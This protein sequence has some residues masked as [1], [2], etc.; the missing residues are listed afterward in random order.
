MIIKYII[1]FT[2]TIQN[3]SHCFCR[4]SSNSTIHGISNEEFKKLLTAITVDK[5][6]TSKY[7]RALISAEDNRPSAK[8][9]GYIAVIFLV[10]AFGTIVALDLPVL[11]LLMKNVFARYHH[12]KEIASKR[13]AVE[14]C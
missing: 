1:S 13:Q 2:V 5:K 12:V 9:I 7:K 10:F 4:C 8:A 11:I 3:G 6:D 14:T